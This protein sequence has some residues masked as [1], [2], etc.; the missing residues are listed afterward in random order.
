MDSYE[1][2][3]RHLNAWVGGE[4]QHLLVV[5]PG[6]TGKS[7]SAHAILANRCHHVFKGRQTPFFLYSQVCDHPD[8]PIVLDNIAALL[9]D[10]VC[11]DLMKQL[12]ELGERVVRWDSTTSKLDGRP[13]SFRCTA[14]VLIIAN[15]IPDRDA[16][17]EA[18]LDR[19]DAICFAPRK[20][21]VIARMRELFPAEP[22]QNLIT[23]IE[24]L[25]VLPSLRTLVKARAWR[26]SSKLDLIEELYSEC[27]VPEPIRILLEIM[28]SAPAAEH[29]D[30]YVARTGLT[31]RTFRRHR[32]IAEELI[33]CRKRAD[34]CPNGHSPPSRAAGIADE[35]P[36]SSKGQ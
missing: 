15:S 30:R 28:E 20:A 3:H 11:R 14:P 2:F 26:D 8:R 7:R 29:C 1:R 24:E 12:T 9:R 6:G 18:I 10:A 32:A 16:D 23:L 25:P 31:D 13:T 22:D 4:I 27:G 19:V 34:A 33:E 36:S 35:T 21:E 5:G 17:L